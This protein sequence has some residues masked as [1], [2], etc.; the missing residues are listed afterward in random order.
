[1]LEELGLTSRFMPGAEIYVMDVVD[2]VSRL[3]TTAGEGGTHVIVHCESGRTSLAVAAAFLA[4]SGGHSSQ[5]AA[6]M[7]VQAAAPSGLECDATE[8]KRVAALA[9]SLRASSGGK[10]GR[11]WANEAAPAQQQWQKP[12]GAASGRE[13][14]VDAEDSGSEPES[15]GGSP[16]PSWAQRAAAGEFGHN[17]ATFVAQSDGLDDGWTTVQ[18]PPKRS[19]SNG[20][21]RGYDAP[22]V[23]GKPSIAVER[24]LR[25]AAKECKEEREE[26][27]AGGATR[28]GE[29]CALASVSF[30]AIPR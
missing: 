24:P 30:A 15:D 19:G 20:Y 17:A 23:G 12:S 21:G 22:R 2:A 9:L 16:E 7:V 27:S 13:A 10:K 3:V 28:R 18:Q 5:L 4:V 11:S 29:D 26:E 1:M 8:A 14:E 25:Q 6:E